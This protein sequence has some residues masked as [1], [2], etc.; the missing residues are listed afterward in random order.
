MQRKH[1]GVDDLQR[2]R[3]LD[4]H[5]VQGAGELAHTHRVVLCGDFN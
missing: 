4:R 2:S 3:T 5:L 1:W